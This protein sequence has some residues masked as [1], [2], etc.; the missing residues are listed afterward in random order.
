MTPNTRLTLFTPG[1]AAL[2]SELFGTGRIENQLTRFSRLPLC[3]YKKLKLPADMDLI[4]RGIRCRRLM[5]ATTELMS[6]EEL[7]KHKWY[8]PENKAGE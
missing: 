3:E 1:E 6:R 8:K 5:K 4:V 7:V 2:F